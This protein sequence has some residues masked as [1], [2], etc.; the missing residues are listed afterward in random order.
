MR[1]AICVIISLAIVSLA[2]SAK[3]STDDTSNPLYKNAPV[4]TA[5]DTSGLPA[6]P[7]GFVHPGVLVN[8]AQLDEIRQRVASDKEPQKTA[9]E[10]LKSNKL[11][12]V[13]YTPHPRATVECGSYSNPDLGCKDEQADSEAAYAQALL[14]YISRDKTYAENALKIMN[15]WSSTLTGGHTNSNGQVQASWTGDVWPR[16]A[17]IIRYS[18]KGW[19]DS[20]IAKFQ[21]MLRTQYLP[22]LIHGTCENG[23]KEETISEALINIGVFN[24]DRAAFDWGIKIWRGRT[25][26]IIYLKTDGPKPIEPAGCGPAIWGN[27]GFT[28]EFVDGLLQETAR[29]SQ[30]AN[31][32]FAGMVNAAETARQ[33]GIDLY[34]EEGKRIMAAM[35][36]QAQYLPPNNAKPPEKLEFNL[37]PTW[38]IAYNEF[39]NRLGYR[40]PKMAAVIPGNH[41]TGVN[42]HMDWETLTHGDIGSVGLPPIKKQ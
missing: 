22:S 10:A 25:P 39:H 1:L 6:K 36:F 31:M 2:F 19:P 38:E 13:D 37:H 32:A 18:Y 21:N 28:P 24:D 15:A 5:P 4:S 12:A 41:P 26:A 7:A 8:R 14:W 27:K 34:G 20:D 3:K 16:A 42:H 29:D 11:A 17:E 35:E 9:F 33:Q 30:H 23:N 40:L